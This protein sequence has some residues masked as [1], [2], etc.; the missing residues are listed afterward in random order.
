[1][2]R[3]SGLDAAIMDPLDSELMDVAITTDL[4]CGQTIYCDS[5]LEAARSK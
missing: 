3:G 4:L 5:F 2:A 1:M